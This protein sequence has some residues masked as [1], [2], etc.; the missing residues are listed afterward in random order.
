MATSP[1]VVEVSNKL[2]VQSLKEFIELAKAK[3]GGLNVANQ[4][5]GTTS[6]LTTA[7]F[8]S[9]AGV[10]FNQVP[11]S[12]T[13]PALN[14]LVAGHVDAF[15]DN[16]SSSLG[17]HQAG[18]I[19]ILAV[20][21]TS[22][23]PQLPDVPTVSETALPGFSATAWYA[24]M[25]P[26]GTADAIIDKV[27]KDVISV[28]GQPDVQKKLLDQAATP[29]ANSP[30]EAAAFIASESKLWGDVIRKAGVKLGG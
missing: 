30:Q 24:I 21:S 1:N 6:H 8:E 23:V 22:R 13:A 28:I 4:G 25:A 3:P 29:V 10:R 26:H 2:G 16:L 5:I 19:K 7:M 12:G 20:C 14:D 18:T 27:N 11:Y 15:F 9:L 17:Q